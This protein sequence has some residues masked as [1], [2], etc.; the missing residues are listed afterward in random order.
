MILSPTCGFREDCVC[1]RTTENLGR[2]IGR[3]TVF[4]KRNKNR[5]FAQCRGRGG[6]CPSRRSDI[7]SLGFVSGTYSCWSGECGS[8]PGPHTP[9]PCHAR[10]RQA[11]P[12]RGPGRR[13]RAGVHPTAFELSVCLP[14][15]STGTHRPLRAQLKGHTRDAGLGADLQLCL[16]TEAAP[17]FSCPQVFRQVIAPHPDKC[18]GAFGR[19]GRQQSRTQRTRLKG[20]VTGQGEGG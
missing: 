4:S 15:L 10:R 17:G 3:T 1:Q 2:G 5:A 14:R 16:R 12:T 11:G 18:L 6:N 7:L 13:E 20:R 9:R 8:S 19:R